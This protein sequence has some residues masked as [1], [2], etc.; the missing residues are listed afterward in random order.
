MYLCEYV[1]C[2]PVMARDKREGWMSGDRV[3]HGLWATPSGCWE[4][5]CPLEEQKLLFTTEQSSQAHN[6]SNF[7]FL[8]LSKALSSQTPFA[9]K[10]TREPSELRACFLLYIVGFWG[11]R[12]QSDISENQSRKFWV[13]VPPQKQLIKERH[14]LESTSSELWTYLNRQTLPQAGRPTGDGE[15][16]LNRR[17]LWNV[18][19]PHAPIVQLWSWRWYPV[20]YEDS[21]CWKDQSTV[22]SNICGCLF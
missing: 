6:P 15:Q 3:R 9:L 7:Y 18:N 4:P 19:Q 8:L 12:A 5:N 1:M 13:P 21:W 16:S 11:T 22:P 17:G 20:S 14:L 2:M 10:L